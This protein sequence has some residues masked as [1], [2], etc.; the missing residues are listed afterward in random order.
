[1]NG[2]FTLDLPIPLALLTWTSFR[3]MKIEARD[4]RPREVVAL[5]QWFIKRHVRSRRSANGRDP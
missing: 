2:G 3:E 1:M 5:A 4:L